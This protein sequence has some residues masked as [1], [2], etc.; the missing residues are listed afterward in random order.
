M[1]TQQANAENDTGPAAEPSLRELLDLQT[2]NQAKEEDA[3][4]IVP[5]EDAMRGPGHVAWKLIQ[6]AKTDSFA[7]NDEQILLIALCTWPLEQAWRTHVRKQQTTCATVNTLRK[8]PNDLCLPRMGAIGGGGCGKTTV[9]Q[10]VVVPTLRTFFGKVLLTAPSN[11]AARGFD[12]SAKTL[13]SVSGMK[14]Q[15]SMRTSNLHIKSDQMRKRM[16]ANQTHAR[17]WVH[18]E[19]LQTA[20]PL[21]HAAA[22]RTT[23][24][25]E[26]AYKLDT[27]RYAQPN[28]IIGKISFLA[29]CGDHL[30]LP[31]VPK[32]SGLL[33]PL[34]NT[35]DE[36]SRSLYV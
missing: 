16:D 11:R 23:Y 36:Q 29:L 5:L 3:C 26:H 30:Q 27:R 18:D 9:M 31:P 8:L 12:P 19:A 15:D 21:W 2:R 34:E 28:E 17:G 22:L 25:R 4:V 14:S 24:A 13:H 20:A 6:D 32:S 35:S 7:F 10:T 33:A 1:R